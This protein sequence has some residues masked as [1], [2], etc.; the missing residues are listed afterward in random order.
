VHAHYYYLAALLSGGLD[1]LR[2]S[3]IVEVH[4]IHLA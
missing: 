3:R 4:T 1:G 2:W